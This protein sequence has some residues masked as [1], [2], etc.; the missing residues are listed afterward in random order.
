MCS[1]YNFKK[2]LDDFVLFLIVFVIFLVFLCYS[3]NSKGRGFISSIIL[4]VSMILF[5][6]TAIRLC[7]YGPFSWMR[8]IK[9]CCKDELAT[10]EDDSQV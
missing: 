10:E 2:F 9:K 4:G 6:F 7:E 1:D 8:K 5:F 3:T